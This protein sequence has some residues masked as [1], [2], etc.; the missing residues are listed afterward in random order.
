M[1]FWQRLSF[2]RKVFLLF[3]THAALLLVFVFLRFIDADEGLYLSAGRE[4]WNG[5][6]PYLDFVYVQ[7]PYY[8]Y[9][10][11]PFA[12][13]G[14][15]GLFVSRL[16]SAMAALL[17]GFLLF[18]LGR[19][20]WGD[21]GGFFLWISWILSGLA[22][23]WGSVAK[24][25]AWGDF[26]LLLSFWVLAG[27]EIE[28]KTGLF[29][30]GL[31]AGMAANF[32]AFLL[33]PAGLFGFFAGEKGRRLPGFLLWVLGFGAALAFTLYFLLQDPQNFFFNNYTYHRLWGNELVEAGRFGF[34]E[35][36]ATLGKF[37]FLPQNLV[38]YLLALAGLFLR[39]ADAWRRR[40]QNMAF[41]AALALHLVFLASTPSLT[42][43]YAETLPYLVLLAG[44]GFNYLRE[45]WISIPRWMGWG[46]GLVQIVS[47]AIIANI[48]LLG[49][50][51]RDRFFLLKNVRPIVDYLKRG[52]T[53][54]DTVF[55]EWPG[56]AVLAV[57][58][59][60]KGTE[61]IGLDVAHLLSAEEKQKYHILDSVGVAELL[62]LKKVR[63]VV[64][65]GVI[66]ETQSAPRSRNYSLV[67][68]AGPARVYRRNE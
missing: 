16:I 5:Q 63:W 49:N 7:T 52:G 62:S 58:Q 57:M 53:P 35:R 1:K 54:T 14:W 60:P 32:R 12:H 6:R 29:F 9:F 43:Y 18:L 38:L 44:F 19:R 23:T 28:K 8:P 4:V 45:K 40:V 66:E 33:F 15:S 26:L 34:A 51:E 46:W 61:T 55:S 21:A 36:I 56:Y 47:L 67:F 59:L 2:G 13:L 37:A 3:L 17:T 41:G 10:I 31:A 42:Q 48:F 27:G 25:A 64:T 50:R 24:P 22:L 39:P 65:W 20:L 30:S 68:D 11:A